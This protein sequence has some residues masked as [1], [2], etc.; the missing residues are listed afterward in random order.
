VQVQFH[1]FLTSA[2]NGG[3]WSASQPAALSQGESPWYPLDRR[4]GRPQGPSGRGSEEKNSWPL[5]GLEPPIILPIAQRYT[6]G[7]AALYKSQSSSLYSTL[8]CSVTLYL[9]GPTIMLK[10]FFYMGVVFNVLIAIW[11]GK[12]WG[13]FG[14]WWT[15]GFCDKRDSVGQMVSVTCLRTTLNHITQPHNLHSSLS[16]AKVLKSRGYDGQYIKRA[17]ENKKCIQNYC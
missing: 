8:T 7:T 5:P 3:E 13:L 2:L 6:S 14:R 4:L 11:S 15:F 9:V 17:W 10:P 1:A 16:N 12:E